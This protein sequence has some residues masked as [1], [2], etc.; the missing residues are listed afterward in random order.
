[1][2]TTKAVMQVRVVGLGVAGSDG[3]PTLTVET[4]VSGAR[5][6]IPTTLEVVEAA[7]KHIN[8]TGAL[9][10]TLDLAP[11]ASGG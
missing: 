7:G 11:P 4:L 9:T 6:E 10:L 8:R 1:M 2:I 3:R 5:L